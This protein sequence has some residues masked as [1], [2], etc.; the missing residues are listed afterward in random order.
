MG[1]REDIRTVFEKDPAARSKLEVICCYPG[2]HAVWIHRVAHSLWNKNFYFAARLLSHFSRM[3]TGIEIH[4][5]ATL[6]RRVFIDHGSGVVI[7]ETAEVGDD[8]LI[9][10]GV[11]LGG[12]SLERTKRHPTIENEVVIGSGA[13]V[14]GPITIGKG[15]KI[16]AGSVV[17]RPVPAGATAVGVP[18]RIAE[19]HPGATSQLDQNKLPDPA[20]RMVS[21][22]LD[23]LSKLEEQFQ[24]HEKLFYGH[25]YTPYGD[26]LK[27]DEQIYAQLKE[28]IDPEVGVDIVKMGF[29]KEVIVNGTNADI[30]L[31]LTTNLCPMADYFKDQIRR[32]VLNVEGIEEV[33]VN[34]LDEPWTWEKLRKNSLPLK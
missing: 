13:A 10:M 27:K 32:K 23:R 34:I 4:P 7:G 24:V 12:T 1:I 33:S 5:G 8:V 29:V 3:F 11:V 15:A 26:E 2:L 22:M 18:A 20:L 14:L 31:V 16:G 28:V 17:V 6:G 9:Y 30:N 19:T 25:A 21:Q